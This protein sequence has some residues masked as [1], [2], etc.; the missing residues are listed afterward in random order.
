MKGQ[1]GLSEVAISRFIPEDLP[2]TAAS[3]ANQSVNVAQRNT[4]LNAPIAQTTEPS[5]A[6]S[7]YIEHPSNMTST[8]SMPALGPNIGS[9][10]GTEGYLQFWSSST[11]QDPT[12]RFFGRDLEPMTLAESFSQFLQD[13][14]TPEGLQAMTSWIDLS[15]AP[16]LPVV[17]PGALIEEEEVASV[18]SMSVNAS[19]RS[20]SNDATEEGV[21]AILIGMA[22]A[23]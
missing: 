11:Y 14:S 15:A 16:D 22:D 3:S 18:D 2:G 9:T 7:A 5:P 20:S 12:K 23:I 21:A 19:P 13:I 10:L 8:T 6:V 1:Q 17:E 4:V